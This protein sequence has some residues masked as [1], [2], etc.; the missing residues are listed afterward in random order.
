[1]KPVIIDTESG[2]ID[3]IRRVP[4]PNRDE[5]PP[6]CSLDLIV[7]HG[8]SLPPG[9]FGGQWIDRFF[10]NDLPTEVHP[11]FATIA[12]LR[13]SAHIL[14]AR[15]AAMTQYVPFTERAWHAGESNYCG[16]SSCN[17][18]SVGIELEGADDLP[19]DQAQYVSLANLV[20]TLQQTYPSLCSAEIVGHC[21]IAPGRKTDP[22][23]SFEWTRLS[24]LL[25]NIET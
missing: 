8:I 4:S 9:Q 24:R 2:W 18:F 3:G 23:A 15:D 21:D 19:Y 20:R 5:R 6:G 11:Y 10:A 22:G 13:V 16:R 12:E 7:V 14:I 25:E 17:D 1:M